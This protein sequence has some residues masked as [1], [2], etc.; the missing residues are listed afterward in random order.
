MRI[1]RARSPLVSVIVVLG[2]SMASA[3][4]EN[5]TTSEDLP[6]DET[7]SPASEPTSPGGETVFAGDERWIAY[8]TDRGGS[9]GIWLVHPDGSD[10]HRI[11]TDLSGE[12]L[13]PDWS[14]DG[15]HLAFTTRGGPSEALFEYD[16]ATDTSRQLFA[17][18]HPCLGDD[19]PVY[20]PDGTSVAFI[21]AL[22]PFT[23]AGPADCGL[24]VGDVATGATRQITS[25][26]QCL[27]EYQ[28]HW[29]PDGSQLTYWRWREDASGTTGTAV[30]VIEADG[31][32]ERQLTDWE[33]FAGSP[34]W[35]P[36]G[37]WIVY[38]TYPCRRSNAVRSQTCSRRAPT[39][40]EPS[41]SPRTTPRTCAQ[42]SRATHRTARGS[43]SRRSPRRAGPC[44]RFRPT[45][46]H[47][48]RSR[49]RGS[50]PTAPGSHST[51]KVAPSGAAT[52][53]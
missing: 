8:Q 21:R 46:V 15:T 53:V 37:G 39:D 6:V 50:T 28:P 32:G 24:W 13:L 31:T 20:S 47:P 33:T 38:S 17:C 1:R 5:G 26:A 4:G 40:P 49:G 30:F 52:A 51:L 14:P 3:C 23:D 42:R 18:E 9:E 27:R 43:S 44:R 41:R 34:D 22:A 48:S 19:E 45:A 10:D 36:D 2:L 35:S 12:Q 16:L 11:A 29:S 7:T 25:N